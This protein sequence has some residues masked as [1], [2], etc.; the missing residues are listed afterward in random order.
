MSDGGLSFRS[1]GELDTIA[2]GERIGRALL[3]GDLLSL[4]GPLGAGKTVLVRGI[5]QGLGAD[6]RVVR[7]PT[8]VLHH[9]YP[10]SLPLHHIDLY[11]LGPD[12]DPTFLDFDGLLQD[13][14]IAVEWGELADLRRFDP[15][16]ISIDGDAD[17]GRHC[18]LE[19]GAPHRLAAAWDSADPRMTSLRALRR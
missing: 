4:R 17:G 14:A 18:V 1:R 13:G 3:P 6:P 12:A 7:S 19:P 8:F 9:V 2:L 15:V 16:R 5:A 10:T 11:R